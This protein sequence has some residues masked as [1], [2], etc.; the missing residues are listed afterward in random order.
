MH[1]LSK[2]KP[3]EILSFLTRRWQ[4]MPSMCNLIVKPKRW[5]QGHGEAVGSGKMA[6]APVLVFWDDHKPKDHTLGAGGGGSFENRCLFLPVLEAGS[7]RSGCRQGWFLPRPREKAL[8]QASVL[9]PGVWQAIFG[10]HWPP[11]TPVFTWHSPSISA[12]MSKY[13]LFIR[14]PVLLA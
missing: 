5:A 14:T 1:L 8:L 2:A 13:P 7:P 4:Q 11:L 9:A 10:T 6:Y 3:Q 12:L